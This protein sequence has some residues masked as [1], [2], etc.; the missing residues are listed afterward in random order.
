MSDYAANDDARLVAQRRAV[1]ARLSELLDVPV[2]PDWDPWQALHPDDALIY[3]HLLD[4]AS[5]IVW[6]PAPP[7]EEEV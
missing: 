2:D 3:E 4:F 6:G 1:L 5:R 7:P